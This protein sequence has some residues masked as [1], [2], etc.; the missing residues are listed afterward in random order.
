FLHYLPVSRRRHRQLSRPI[1]LR[2]HS[3]ARAKAERAAA[4]PLHGPRLAPPIQPRPPAL[5]AP[6][7][8]GQTKSRSPRRQACRK[9]AQDTNERKPDGSRAYLTLRSASSRKS[10]ANKP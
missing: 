7:S 5:L 3:L 6:L 2:C 8:E 10:V 1:F 9:T 4:A